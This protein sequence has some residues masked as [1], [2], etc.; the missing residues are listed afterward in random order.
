MT[1]NVEEGISTSSHSNDSRGSASPPRALSPS[2]VQ[3]QQDMVNLLSGL[4]MRKLTSGSSSG[5]SEVTPLLNGS[6]EGPC[7]AYS[8]RNRDDEGELV[9]SLSTV[10]SK[11]DAIREKSRFLGILKH[12]KLVLLSAVMIFCVV[13]LTLIKV[14]D[15][16]WNSITVTRG[17]PVQ[18]NVTADM[19]YKKEILHLRTKGPFLPGEYYG[20]SR[21]LVTFTVARIYKNGTYEQI[22]TEWELL[23]APETRDFEVDAKVLEHDFSLK[24]EEMSD[25]NT[26][27]LTVST[28]KRRDYVS[29]FIDVSVRPELAVGQIIMAICVLIGLYILIIFEV[30]HRTLAA[31]IGATVAISCL[32]L[33]GARPSLMEVMSWMDVETLGL[34]F[35]MMILVSILCETG[36]FDYVAVL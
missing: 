34:L 18:I 29:L 35:G 16:S 17:K 10:R 12:V 2:I 26:Y 25:S 11:D 14:H 32:A 3:Q 36:F 24:P 7:Y 15:D 22:S 8:S 30:V 27:Q 19:D 21:N 6:H 9:D 33:V 13:S 23:L 20:I 5:S 4:N 31:M 28:N 1:M